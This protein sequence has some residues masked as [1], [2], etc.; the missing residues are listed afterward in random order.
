MAEQTGESL[1]VQPSE[2]G[3]RLDLFLAERL[4]LSRGRARRLLASGA[5][6]IGGRPV[7]MK[8]SEAKALLQTGKKKGKLKR[9]ADRAWEKRSP[10]GR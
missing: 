7:V 4:S 1:E 3:R 9:A 5:V 8:D 10:N 2:A 6:R